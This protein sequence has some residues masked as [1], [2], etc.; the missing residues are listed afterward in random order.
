MNTSLNMPPGMKNTTMKNKSD[1]E[2]G[3]EKSGPS[4]RERVVYV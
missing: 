1:E 2:P 4:T 3:E